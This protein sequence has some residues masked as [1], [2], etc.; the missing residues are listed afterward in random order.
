MSSGSENSLEGKDLFE[1]YG[2]KVDVEE[3]FVDGDGED[4]E[5]FDEDGE[6]SEDLFGDDEFGDN[7]CDV[8]D[9]ELEVDDSDF[10]DERLL[11]K[12]SNVGEGDVEGGDDSGVVADPDD[13]V[14][15]EI[16]KLVGQAKDEM[17]PQCSKDL[18]VKVYE[19]YVK[20]RDEKGMCFTN[21]SSV[22]AYMKVLSG[23]YKPSTMWQRCSILK[24]MIAKEEGVNIYSYGTLIGFM[25]QKS[26]GYE[27]KKS[28]VFSTEQMKL[29]LGSAPDQIYLL[30]KVM[31]FFYFYFCL[32]YLYLIFIV[33][34]CFR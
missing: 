27:P 24:T 30:D 9:G 32:W 21:E 15:Y 8:S 13:E 7:G 29:F 14:P 3:E 16:R 5:L 31:V 17:L 1:E 12:S 34:F 23:K 19:D 18:Y 33:Y 26:N 22:L 28:R 25:R 2:V 20:W 10:L 4:G 11:G 6:G